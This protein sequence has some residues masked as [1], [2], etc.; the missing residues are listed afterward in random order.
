MTT[1]TWKGG[2]KGAIRATYIVVM[3]I[4]ADHSGGRVPLSSLSY[5]NLRKQEKYSQVRV[6]RDAVKSTAATVRQ[7]HGAKVHYDHSR[8]WGAQRD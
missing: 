8:K 4:S 6:N 1:Q 3:P 7:W 5:N 2:R